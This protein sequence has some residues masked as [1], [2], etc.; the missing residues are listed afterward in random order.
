VRLPNTTTSPAWFSAWRDQSKKVGADGPKV[1]AEEDAQS[2]ALFGL[3]ILFAF[4]QQPTR[5]LQNWRPTFHRHAARFSS[6]HFVE[7]L[8]HLRH[9]MEAIRGYEEPR[10][11]SRGWP[12]NRVVLVQ[13]EVESGRSPLARAAETTTGFKNE[14][15]LGL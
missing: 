1:V 9:D 7:S 10:S 8:V 13:R 6:A 11:T 4:E 2:E 5:F 12:S 14:F 15:R 3:R